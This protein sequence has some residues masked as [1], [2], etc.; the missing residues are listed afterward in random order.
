[1]V[2]DN[3]HTLEACVESGKLENRDSFTVV[4][5]Y[6]GRPRVF[7]NVINPVQLLLLSLDYL[8]CCDISGFRGSGLFCLDNKITRIGSVFVSILSRRDVMR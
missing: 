4:V 5:R 1:M 8:S 2:V 6:K 7:F 3:G